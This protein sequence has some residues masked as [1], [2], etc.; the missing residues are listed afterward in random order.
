MAVNIVTYF[1]TLSRPTQLP[2]G[3]YSYRKFISSARYNID[4]W[5]L[6]CF[7]KHRSIKLTKTVANENE[8]NVENALKG[9][10]GKVAEMRKSFNTKL[11][12][13]ILD[14]Q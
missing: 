11:R 13:I 12:H 6:C 10:I 14:K 2:L 1:S 5:L 4:D 8:E 9:K 7:D 3:S